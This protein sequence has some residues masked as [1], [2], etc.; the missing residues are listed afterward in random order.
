M[1]EVMDDSK[2]R[3][4]SK[5]K[6]IGHRQNEPCPLCGERTFCVDCGLC[7]SC[8]YSTDPDPEDVN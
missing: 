8:K 1:G 6:I 5:Y 2:N 7:R 4:I 3:D